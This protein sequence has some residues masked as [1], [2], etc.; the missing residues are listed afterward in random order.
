M[1]SK[2][3]NSPAFSVD[4]HEPDEQSPPGLLYELELFDLSGE[5]SYVQWFQQYEGDPKGKAESELQDFLKSYE[6]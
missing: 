6:G 3:T 1:T 4:R 2:T 5:G